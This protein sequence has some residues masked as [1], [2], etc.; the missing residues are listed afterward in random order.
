MKTLDRTLAKEIKAANGDE[1][2]EAKFSLL[3]KIHKAAEDMS[4]PDIAERFDEMLVKHG[5]AVTA[6]CI[7]ATLWTRKERLELGG[8]ELMWATKVLELW[9]TKPKSETGVGHAYIDDQLHPTR[10]LEYA[11]SFMECTTEG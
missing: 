5:R 2:R 11:A 4:T 3:H 1:S 6:I 9:T 7:A 8:W 10:I